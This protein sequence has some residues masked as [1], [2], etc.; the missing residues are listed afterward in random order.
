M[1]YL[2]EI[3]RIIDYGLRGQKQQLYSQINLLIKQLNKKG[4]IRSA[5]ILLKKISVKDEHI[6]PNAFQFN[7]PIPVEKDN[8]FPLADFQ[9]FEV[10]DIWI[11]L[12][13]NLQKNIDLFLS[14]LENKEKLKS[15]NIPLNPTMLLYGPPG[16]GKSKL[17]AYIASQLSL[18]LITA[19]S[20]ALISSYLGSTSKNIRMLM[21]YAQEQPCILFLDEFDALAKGRNDANEIGEL[22]RVVVSLLQ[23]I[24]ALDNVILIAATNH[25]ELL[26]KAVWRRFQYKIEI[27]L[28]HKEIREAITKHI[29]SDIDKKNLALFIELTH[30]LSGADIEA[31]VYE[32]KR[33]KVLNNNLLDFKKLL[34][35]ALLSHNNNL[36]F[37]K[38]NIKEEVL[39]IKK[40]F[41]LS[42]EK[43]A[44]IFAISKTYVGKILKES[45][46]NE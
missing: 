33:E 41:N 4:D 44:K 30:G 1:D 17:A 42:Y 37:L 12:P 24:D 36:T 26:D 45:I 7:R 40:K 2:P 6:T 38:H 8:R 9:K 3:T 43:I 31:I 32:F 25:P 21:D 46:E 22:K 20:D 5:E 14:Y 35:L 39:Y 13:E 16:T 29:L 15:E 34:Q 19:R 10:N 18:P 28:P 11:E 27:E 23:N